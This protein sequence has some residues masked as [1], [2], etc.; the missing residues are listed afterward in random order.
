VW[1]DRH[2]TGDPVRQTNNRGMVSFVPD[3]KLGPGTQWIINLDHNPT[4]EQQGFRLK[5]ARVT[6]QKPTLG[7]NTP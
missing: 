6:D 4:L 5:R 3:G 2:I 7:A 1:R